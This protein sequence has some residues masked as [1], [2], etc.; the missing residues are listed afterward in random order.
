M[1][2][3]FVEKGRLTSEELDAAL[4]QQRETGEPLG[5][6]LVAREHISR[7]DLAAALS[8]QWTWRSEEPAAEATPVAEPGTTETAP[9][10]EVRG[11]PAHD[12]VADLKAELAATHQQLTAAE[13]RLDTLEGDVSD[14]TKAFGA[15]QKFLHART[16]EL[17]ALRAASEPPETPLVG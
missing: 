14:L 15:L 4:A 10:E 1:G 6:I 12:L 11:A 13:A 3:L 9:V 16:Q 5:E 17:E 8:T 2:Q 7:V